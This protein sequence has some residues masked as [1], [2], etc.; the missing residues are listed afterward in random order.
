MNTRIIHRKMN[1]EASAKVIEMYLRS[2]VETPKTEYRRLDTKPRLVHY[3]PIV[4]SKDD[5]S[6]SSR[7]RLAWK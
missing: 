1:R 3:E 7:R 5:I 6:D 2:V 4:E